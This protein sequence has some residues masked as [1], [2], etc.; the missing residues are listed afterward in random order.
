M[1]P[2]WCKTYSIIL[3]FC[4]IMGTCENT[5]DFFI[6][7]YHALRPCFPNLKETFM[8]QAQKKSQSSKMCHQRCLCVPERRSQARNFYEVCVRFG[9]TF[10][11]VRLLLNGFGVRSITSTGWTKKN[12]R[13]LQWVVGLANKWRR[14]F[15]KVVNFFGPPCSII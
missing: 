7:K 12:V 14:H 5:L 11:S 9:R 1:S 6:L 3:I 8:W 2:I 13:L 15:V 10:G 4:V